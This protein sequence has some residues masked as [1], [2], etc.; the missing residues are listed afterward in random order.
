[1]VVL[2]SIEDMID[3]YSKRD[4]VEL[5]LVSLTGFGSAPGCLVDS[6]GLVAQILS[7]GELW[8][9]LVD[10]GPLSQGGDWMWLELP[11]PSECTS[12]LGQVYPSS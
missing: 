11:L 1:M 8:L 5:C 10:L 12:V 6:K 9:R 2:D 7:Q 4:E 3:G